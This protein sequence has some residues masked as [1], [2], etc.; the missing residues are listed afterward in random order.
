M[1]H[2]TPHFNLQNPDRIWHT[3][4]E[5]ILPISLALTSLLT[6]KAGN[7]TDDTNTDNGFWGQ[8]IINRAE[9]GSILTRYLK[10]R[11]D[12][13]GILQGNITEIEAIR[14]EINDRLQFLIHENLAHTIMVEIEARKNHYAIFIRIDEHL[15]QF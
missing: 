4:K 13:G 12:A 10:N 14:Q 9:I 15:L 7:D 3:D 2:F 11:H 5:Q 6:Q 1:W 8:S